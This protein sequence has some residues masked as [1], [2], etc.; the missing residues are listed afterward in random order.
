MSCQNLCVR[1]DQGRARLAQRSRRTNAELLLLGLLD[2]EAILGR[3]FAG[4]VGCG[5]RTSSAAL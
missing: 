4:A 2:L 5:Y 1:H 3:D